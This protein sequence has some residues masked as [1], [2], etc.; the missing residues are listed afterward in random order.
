MIKI[1]DCVERI[2]NGYVG[3]TRDIYVAK[4]VPYILARQIKN[5]QLL[6]DEKTF[7]TEAFNEKNKR[8]KLKSGDVLMVQSGHI[9]ETAVVPPEHEGHN[10]HA[11]IVMTPRIRMIIGKFFSA[12]LSTRR[13]RQEYQLIKTGQTLPHLNCRDVKKLAIPVPTIEAQRRFVEVT[14]QIDRSVSEL[15]TALEL[16]EQAFASLQHRAF[17]GEL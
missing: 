14:S 8:S 11:L 9:G 16:A 3:A 13:M 15:R 7:I 6:F 17:R 10:C 2:T 4:G 5:G 1:E 12:A